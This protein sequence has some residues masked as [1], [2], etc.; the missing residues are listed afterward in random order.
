MIDFFW[1]IGEVVDG[2]GDSIEKKTL[3]GVTYDFGNF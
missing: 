1:Q 3:H 2:P